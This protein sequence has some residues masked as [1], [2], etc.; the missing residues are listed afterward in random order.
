MPFRF[1]YR[2]ADISAL[3][4]SFVSAEMYICCTV[5]LMCSISLTLQ[6]S[7]MIFC[8]VCRGLQCPAP[9]KRRSTDQLATT[10]ST[11][12]P[13][14][15]IIYMYIYKYIFAHKVT[16]N[17]N[18]NISLFLIHIYISVLCHNFCTYPIFIINCAKSVKMYL[19]YDSFQAGT[20]IRLTF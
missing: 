15:Y 18:D 8:S 16:I 1:V 10:G 13:N 11:T 6:R 9:C 17:I 4:C 12:A 5:R 3:S 19:G 2:T 14:K 20:F 7:R